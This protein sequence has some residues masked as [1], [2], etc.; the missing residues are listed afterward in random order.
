MARNRL[1]AADW[2]PLF[3][4]N[5]NCKYHKGSP[6]QWPYKKIGFYVRQ[7]KPHRI[8]R[9]ICQHCRRS[10]SRQTFSTTYWQKRPDLDH[11]IF[12]R[13]N[14]C[15]ANRQ[16]ARDLRV[17]PETVNRHLA[18]LGRHC[19]IYHWQLMQDGVSHRGDIVVDGLESFEYS[20]YYPFH[21]NV[22]VDNTSGLFLFFTDSPLRR[23]GRMTAYQKRRRSELEARLGCPDPRAVE[24]DMA[25]LL[26]TVLTG[27][28]SVVLYS[29]DHRAYP[30][31]L[32][33][34]GLGNVHQVTSSRERRDRRNP[35]WEVN[36]LELLVRHGGANHK[37]ETIAWSKRRQSS[38]ERLAIMLVW[39]NYVKWRYEKGCRQTPGMLSGLTDRK[40]EVEDILG[41]RL[42]VSRINLPLRWREYYARSVQT[43]VLGH[44][45]RHN[46]KYAY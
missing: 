15:M 41:E 5:P 13:T 43:P 30:R 12:M 6:R 31:A 19:L 23:K 40:L 1:G 4:P 22:A 45:R 27:R 39:R 25:A 16:I 3:C 28:P 18:R 20:Q 35:L 11:K 34:A 24:K 42:F 21:H 37:R 2:Q 36:L 46:L 14:G 32:R 9:F 17:S 44:N 38:A 10:F 7:Q 26:E 8:Q 33:C 29:D